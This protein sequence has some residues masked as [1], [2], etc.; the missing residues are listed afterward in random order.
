MGPVS[1]ATSCA[2]GAS[3]AIRRGRSAFTY[4]AI[5]AIDVWCLFVLLDI[6]MDRGFSEAFKSGT[7]AFLAY[8]LRLV[9]LVALGYLPT[10]VLSI[11]LVAR[12]PP[13]PSRSER[14]L[15][16]ATAWGGWSAILVVCGSVLSGLVLFPSSVLIGWPVLTISGAAFATMGLAD[17]TKRSRRLLVAL[18]LIVATLLIVGSLVAAGHWGE[19]A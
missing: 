13:G 4:L 8:G 6:Q 2:I 10:V 17:D 14:A 5:I 9:P 7:T 16:G 11:E 18:A 3:P 12:T 15:A 1:A 19:P